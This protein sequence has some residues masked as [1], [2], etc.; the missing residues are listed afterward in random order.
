MPDKYGSFAEL[1]SQEPDGF[2]RLH[3]ADRAS[4]VLVMAPH[5]GEIEPGTMI[6]ATTLAGDDLSF[7]VFEG[8]KPG[9]DADLHITSTRFDEP[10]ALAMAARA[11]LVVTV[12]GRRDRDAVARIG[13][14][15]RR[16]I[17]ILVNALQRAGFEASEETDPRLLGRNP[18]N[19]CNRGLLREGLQLELGSALRRRLRAD[20]VALAEFAEAVRS[21]VA[22]LAAAHG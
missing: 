14:A 16:G 20:E 2:W 15:H 3:Y 5:G 7:Y 1:S 4:A 8:C 17:P 6:I 13:G 11:S 19:L 22:S 10:T 12:R 21:V 18:D 9:D